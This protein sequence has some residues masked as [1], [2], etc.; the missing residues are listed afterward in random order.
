M[1]LYAAITLLLFIGSPL[2][3]LSKCSGGSCES[4]SCISNNISYDQYNC[5]S[6]RC[7]KGTRCLFNNYDQPLCKHCLGS[8]DTDN[9]SCISDGR[10]NNFK[11]CVE[12]GYPRDAATESV[13]I[14][15]DHLSCICP[16]PSDSSNKCPL[17]KLAMTILSHSNEIKDNVTYV[18]CVDHPNYDIITQTMAFS[19]CWSY[20]CLPSSFYRRNI[21]AIAISGG[22]M[23]Y[24]LE[25]I[26]TYKNASIGFYKPKDVE[27][28]IAVRT[29]NNV[30]MFNESN[31][32]VMTP[33]DVWTGLN[34]TYFIPVASMNG[35]S[36]SIVLTI[37]DVDDLRP[38]RNTMTG[39]LSA[40]L[41]I[42]KLFSK[43]D[44]VAFQTY[45]GI[46]SVRLRGYYVLL[47]NEFRS[48][49]FIFGCDDLEAQQRALTE[50]RDAFKN[51]DVIDLKISCIS[52]NVNT[53]RSMMQM[54]NDDTII[55]FYITTELPAIEYADS[56]I[57]F[58][59]ILHVII[60][61]VP[62]C[63][64]DQVMLNAFQQYNTNVIGIDTATCECST[65]ISTS[66]YNHTL[67]IST[68]V[69]NAETKSS[70]KLIPVIG[71]VV[72]IVGSIILVIVIMTFVVRHRKKQIQ[73]YDMI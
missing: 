24:N 30:F 41:R 53:R 58:G 50:L 61:F 33:N 49:T 26:P 4:S 48:Y 54:N 13:V 29:K 65:S 57:N 44:V 19:W 14:P 39:N 9:S 66:L 25:S 16:M 35:D 62:H 67:T 40:M 42:D 38:L 15:I 68:Q 32:R 5:P 23:L 28:T 17:N 73:V 18:Q 1:R 70:P 47:A 8:T 7:K 6:V 45:A 43:D 64:C 21:S 3:I 63:A 72:G 60:N 55:N 31:N 36:G 12:L 69:S 51:Y 27:M 34:I 11:V 2:G 46:E 22:S 20:K 59:S 71:V 37:T 56:S 10:S 52:M